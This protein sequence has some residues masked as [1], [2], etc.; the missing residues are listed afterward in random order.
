MEGHTTKKLTTNRHP[1]GLLREGE[2]M[3][4]EIPRMATLAEWMRGAYGCNK[5]QGEA[6]E[7]VSDKCPSAD[8]NILWAMWLAID[9]Y[10]SGMGK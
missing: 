4:D 6:V 8:L 9:A 3:R 7:F 2:I 1:E 5:T 10:V